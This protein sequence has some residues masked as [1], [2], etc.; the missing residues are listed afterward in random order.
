[1]IGAY[2]RG[3]YGERKT[4]HCNNGLHDTLPWYWARLCRA[5]SDSRHSPFASQGSV[6]HLFA[7]RHAG[8]RGMNRRGNRPAFTN[9]LLKLSKTERHGPWRLGWRGASVCG[10]VT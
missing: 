8:H 6:N 10:R 4:P 7:L 1:V 5:I 3:N 2:R 9:G